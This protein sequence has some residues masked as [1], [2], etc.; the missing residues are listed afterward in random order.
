[1]REEKLSLLGFNK[2]KTRNLIALMTIICAVFLTSYFERNLLATYPIDNNLMT[3]EWY[4]TAEIGGYSDGTAEPRGIDVVGNYAFLTDEDDGLEIVDISNKMTPEFVSE[5]DYHGA[6]VDVV[7][8]DDIAFILDNDMGI[9]FINISDP[10]NPVK[11]GE[12]GIGGPVYD[13]KITGNYTFV[14]NGFNGLRIVNVTDIS[15]PFEIDSFDPGAIAYGVS[16]VEDI[17]YLTTYDSGLYVV[18]ISNPASP[19]YLGSYNDGKI[20]K[21]IWV[22]GDFAYITKGTDGLQILDISNFSDIT[23]LDIIESSYYSPENII[24]DNNLA[25]VTAGTHGL[26]IFNVTNK[27]EIERIGTFVD[28]GEALD[29]SLANGLI[30][31]ADGIDGLEIIGLDTDNDYLADFAETNYY[32]TDPNNPD[33]DQDGLLDG[34]EVYPGNDG[35]VTNP[36]NNDT[37]FDGMPDGWEST[38]SLNPTLNDANGDKDQDG[39]TNLE[40][41]QYGTDPNDFDSD[42]DSFT[43]KEEIDAGTDPND[44]N[45]WPTNQLLNN[46]YWIIGGAILG[47]IAI[48]AVILIIFTRN[49]KPDYDITSNLEDEDLPSETEQ[50]GLEKPEIDLEFDAADL[51][52]I[53]PTPAR[54]EIK[55]SFLRDLLKIKT[56]IIM[57]TSGV[58]LVKYNFTQ[59]IDSA[60]AS[61]FLTAVTNFGMELI[62]EEKGGEGRFSQIGQEGAIFWIFSGRLVR[63]A[64]LLDSESTKEFKKPVARLVKIYEERYREELEFFAGRV[65]DYENSY[66]LLEEYLQIQYLYPMKINEELLEE[67]NIENKKL[68]PIIDYYVTNFDSEI[69]FEIPQIIERAFKKLPAITFDEILEEIIFFVE[70]AIFIP[71]PPEYLN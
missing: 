60:L 53:L 69:T 7:V 28:G 22:E 30:F 62:G 63:I 57:T 55:P 16:I 67:V 26:Q 50:A 15:N 21:K 65:T 29:L 12:F 9:I 39:L 45:D 58:P 47:V 43:D 25:F 49:K 5:I 35:W 66:L 1:L 34:E 61:G 71:I 31:L 24:V 13:I 41:Y 33:V 6:A 64:L 11:E 32:A 42:N 4:Y 14:A 54:R 38:N 56:I 2:A 48:V 59:D 23:Q 19:Q 40:E 44:P 70:N 46:L 18:N 37:D 52:P 27:F 68:A 3:A 17:A 10:S 51:R 8:I 36:K 20:M